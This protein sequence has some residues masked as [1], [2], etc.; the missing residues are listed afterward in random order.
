MKGMQCVFLR[1]M[2]VRWVIRFQQSKGEAEQYVMG[3]CWFC[4]SA[5][6]ALRAAQQMGSVALNNNGLL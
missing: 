2:R 4:W 3:L 5:G 6:D 1:A